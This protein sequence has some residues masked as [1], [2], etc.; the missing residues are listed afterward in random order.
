MNSERFEK[1]SFP[2][3]IYMGGS[4]NPIHIGHLLV[5]RYAAEELGAKKVVLIPAKNP[6]HKETQMADY[7]ERLFLCRLAIHPNYHSLFSVS[8]IERNMEGNSYTYNVLNQ[9][10][11]GFKEKTYWLLGS[12][13]AY[14]IRSWYKFEE[15][16]KHVIFVVVPRGNTNPLSIPLSTEEI[17]HT[18]G[19]QYKIIKAPLFDVS[20][21][22]IRNRLKEH[23]SVSY[24]V[25]AVVEEYI[26]SEG[27][28]SDS[29]PIASL[30]PITA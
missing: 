18:L 1:S 20:S 4:F 12:D 3:R 29:G 14:T 19:C 30:K 22:G 25:P 17:L 23:K 28:Y 11:D 16:K 8:D 10:S 5:A 26:Q 6:Y 7:E 27:L 13:T 21:S 15:I 9:L 2:K 24:L